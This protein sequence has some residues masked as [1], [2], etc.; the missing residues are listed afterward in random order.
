MRRN[1]FLV[2][3]CGMALE[4]CG[5]S[6]YIVSL[7]LPELEALFFPG[8]RQALSKAESLVFACNLGNWLPMAGLFYDWRFGGPRRTVLVA[9]TLTFVGYGGLWVACLHPASSSLWGLRLLFFL[10]GHGSGYFDSCALS[11]NVANFAAHRGAAV[12]TVKAFYGLS[13]S[14]LT[15]IFFAGFYGRASGTPSFLAFL[16]VGLSALGLCTAPVM[17]RLSYG[18]AEEVD[19]PQRRFAFAFGSVL[20][21]A[22]LLAVMGL[23]RSFTALGGVRG[24]SWAALAVTLAGLVP[25]P[26]LAW[27]ASYSFARVALLR[28]EASCQLADTS[29][30]VPTDSSA[31]G[32]GCGRGDARRCGAHE[33]EGE[34]PTATEMAALAHDPSSSR[35][36]A[37][38]GCMPSSTCPAASPIA[39]PVEAPCSSQS[40]SDECEA[41]MASETR[42]ACDRRAIA[43]SLLELPDAW[44]ALRTAEFWLLFVSFFAGTGG[45]LVVTNH[46]ATIVR[47]QLPAAADDDGGMHQATRVTDAL[48]SLFSVTN[49]LGRLG[50]GLGS[51]ALRHLA[52]RPQLFA[53]ATLLMAAAHA[54]LL[55]AGNSKMLF[56]GVLS[57][58][59]SYGASWALLPA[60][61]RAHAR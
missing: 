14:I 58:G 19:R 8:D 33:H 4:M 27:G 12:G 53:L 22:L 3:V 39:C 54:L 34:C 10:W 26:F 13:G 1:R 6:I 21:L 30:T 32:D 55:G 57:A 42:R 50:A 56:A 52:T 36:V 45:G 47:A 11:T 29:S 35:L 9:C 23:L 5:G 61:V 24:F 41:S 40:L 48:I 20:T 28:S 15:Q 43:I 38:D 7:Y 49:C 18:H 37:G 16:A 59:L 44:T 46:L 60:L 51:D 31:G 17:R 2:L 25:L